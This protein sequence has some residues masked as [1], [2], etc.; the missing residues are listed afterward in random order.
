MVNHIFMSE[1]LRYLARLKTFEVHG[2][3]M[4]LPVDQEIVIAENLLRGVSGRK[5]ITNLSDRPQI[6]FGISGTVR[7]T[8]ETRRKVARVFNHPLKSLVYMERNNQNS[9]DVYLMQRVGTLSIS[10]SVGGNN[11]VRR[12][13]ISF[14]TIL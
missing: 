5:H 6:A 4:G 7:Q 14:E 8:P 11:G 3:S 13:S 9:F 12:N 2:G 10:E 1:C